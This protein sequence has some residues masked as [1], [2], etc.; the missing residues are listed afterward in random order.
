MVKDNPERQRFELEVGGQ[1]AIAE[2]RQEPGSI[3]F[4]HTEVP[5]ALRGQGRGS[6]L[7]RGALELVRQR[8]DRVVARCSFIADFIQKNPEFR[9]LLA[10]GRSRQND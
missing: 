10:A 8:G 9:E 1:L 4:V 6:E 2:Y 3:T 7:A 5:P